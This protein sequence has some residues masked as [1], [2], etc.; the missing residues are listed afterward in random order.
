MVQ[1]KVARFLCPTV[2]I[3][4]DHYLETKAGSMTVFAFPWKQIQV[5]VADKFISCLVFNAVLQC[6]SDSDG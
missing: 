2:Y 6:I 5:E 3:D 4:G 1:N